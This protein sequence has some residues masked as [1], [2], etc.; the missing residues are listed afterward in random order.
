MVKI[1]KCLI[2]LKSIE[3]YF[4]RLFF[5][6][7]SL[8]VSYTRKIFVNRQRIKMKIF[9]ILVNLNIHQFFLRFFSKSNCQFRQA[10]RAQTDDW[11]NVIKL[12]TA[13]I[14]E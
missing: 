1:A 11:P 4:E 7:A 8:P 12:F 5:K 13:V 3:I 14:F 10:L 9:T 6:I 2:W